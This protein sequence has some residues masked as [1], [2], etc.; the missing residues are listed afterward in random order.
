M[1]NWFDKIIGT[2]LETKKNKNEGVPDKR[3]WD[4]SWGLVRQSSK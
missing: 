2:E 1:C 4:M 3:E